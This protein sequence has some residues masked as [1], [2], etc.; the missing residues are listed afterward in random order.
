MRKSI[1]NIIKALDCLN[2]VGS[3]EEITSEILKIKPDTPPSSIRRDIQA[4]SSDSKT[5]D[6]SKCQDLFFSA[7]GLGKG[8]W[9]LRDSIHTE[10]TSDSILI[11]K[12]LSKLKY[13]TRK[14]VEIYRIIRD[15]KEAKKIKELYNNKCQFCG[16]TI[17]IKRKNGNTINYSEAHHIIPLG[18]Y[19]HGSDDISNMIVLCP[20]HHVMLDYT[21][22]KIIK[23]DIFVHEAHNISLNSIKYHNKMVKK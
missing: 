12:E 9:A 7:Q 6:K 17:K 21:T 13:P 1:E 5:Y 10:I 22:I 2:G 16:F 20:N 19:H 18:G 8:I 23:K 14:L 3:L 15:T 11:A 4:H